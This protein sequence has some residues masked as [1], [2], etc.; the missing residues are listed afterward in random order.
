M[1]VQ[2]FKSRQILLL[3]L[4][5]L[6][7]DEFLNEKKNFN[8]LSESC[9][10]EILIRFKKSLRIL[11]NYHSKRKLILFIGLPQLLSVEINHFTR[12]I[13]LSKYDNC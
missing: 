8:L 10:I 2:T 12:H 6:K 11:F 3:Y 4:L 9:T 7:T 13:A 5:K 1:K